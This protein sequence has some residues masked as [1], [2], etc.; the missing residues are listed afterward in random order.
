MTKW[1]LAE[2]DKAGRETL[3]LSALFKAILHDLEPDKTQRNLIAVLPKYV[4]K[5]A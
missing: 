3:W 5:I 4:G 2:L 1:L